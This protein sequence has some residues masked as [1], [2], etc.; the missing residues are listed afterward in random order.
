M[1]IGFHYIDAP[2]VNAKKQAFTMLELV[3]V[4]VVLGILAALAL[5][6]MERDGRQQAADNILSAIRYTQHLALLDDKTDPLNVQWQ[7]RFWHI[8]FSSY[9]KDGQT[10][11]FYTVSSSR[12]GDNNVDQDEAATDPSNGRL[13]FNANG[14]SAIDPNESPNIFIGEQYGIT[15][16]D[17]SAC[18]VVTGAS[19]VAP[20][21]P[22]HIAFDHL[23]RPHRG[24]YNA[25]NNFAT[26]T[27]QNCVIRFGSPDFEDF[28]ITI[29][30]QTGHAFING[31]LES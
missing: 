4:I 11:W 3:M 23:G 5:P 18:N 1:D 13:M 16:V 15:T 26:I 29:E 14:D 31:Q 17:F 10:L 27:Q 7:R 25:G 8:R 6:R 28:S 20:G 9:T 2:K 19:G 12:D 24:I 22:Q 30:N 21:N